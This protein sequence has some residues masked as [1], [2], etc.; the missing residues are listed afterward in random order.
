MKKRILLISLMFAAV[1]VS[2][3]ACNGP[4]GLWDR[5]RWAFTVFWEDGDLGAAIDSLKDDGGNYNFPSSNNNL[6]E[7]DR[8]NTDVDDLVY[9]ESEARTTAQN[10]FLDAIG[11]EIGGSVA[12]P[13]GKHDGE[14]LSLVRQLGAATATG[15][16]PKN[17]LG[18][19]PYELLSVGLEKNLIKQ[20]DYIVYDTGEYGHIGVFIGIDGNG[21]VWILDQNWM[22]ARVIAVRNISP[23]Y[24]IYYIDRDQL[25]K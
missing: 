15:N 19:V 5:G 6:S 10:V 22:L 13:E 24:N 21:G 8:Q 3:L 7:G 16:K 11:A 20:G 14:C 23:T 4:I 25:N 17:Y 1:L 9:T 12:D 2:S 18:Q